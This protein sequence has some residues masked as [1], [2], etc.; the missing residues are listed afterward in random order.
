MKVN[1]FIK[2]LI[3]AS[4]LTGFLLTSAC[5]SSRLTINNS[6]ARKVHHSIEKSKVFDKH[7][8]GL[9]I[10]DAQTGEVLYNENGHSHFTPASLTKLFTY[11]VGRSVLPDNMP[12]IDY[13][14]VNDTAI[15]WPYGD[16]EFLN[17]HF[18]S[19]TSLIDSLNNLASAISLSNAQFKDKHF[20]PG[21]AWDD[22]VYSFQTEKSFFPVH[23][24]I[25]SFTL[26]DKEFHKINVTPGYYG[27][28]LTYLPTIGGESFTVKRADFAN[29]FDYNLGPNTQNNEK[30]DVPVSSDKYFLGRL[31]NDILDKPLDILAIPADDYPEKTTMYG[32]A[33]DSLYH[34]MLMESDNHIAEQI[35]LSISYALTD[36]QTTSISTRYAQEEL[37]SFLP[38]N[39]VY[40]DGSGLSRYN[41][42]T[43]ANVASLLKHLYDTDGERLLRHL[44]KGDVRSS[45][46]DKILSFKDPGNDISSS[47]IFV[48]TGSMK[49]VYNFGGYLRTKQGRTLCFAWM[50]NHFTSSRS[51][52][53]TQMLETLRLI[54]EKY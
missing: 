2:T 7:Y 31:L 51:E 48:K 41:Q 29:A 40:V 22:Y 9:Y 47:N 50:N 25:A 18:P 49:N 32:I 26:V 54:Y 42:N 46:P 11:A 1:L 10:M 8:S 43:A 38:D 4:V 39:M 45:E 37:F 33:T 30:R 13:V 3:I 15:I 44:P 52:L 34:I 19:T 24:N 21:W 35:M 27:S 14:I 12:F 23:G 28:W 20:G 17:P 5:T 16:P 36:E 53:E 6:Q